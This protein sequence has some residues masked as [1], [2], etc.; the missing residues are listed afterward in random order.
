ME[1]P[2]LRR[3][4]AV[5]LLAGACFFVS[6]TTGRA[7]DRAWHPAA[8]AARLFDPFV[9]VWDFDCDFYPAGG[10]VT[11]FAG[12][13]SFRWILDGRAMQDIWVGYLRGT[14][15]GERGMGMSVRF[16]DARAAQWKVVFIAPEGGKIL[17]LKGGR[18]GDR[19]VLEGLD[20]DG[21]KLRW[22]F[23]D[24]HEDDFLWRGE[25]SSDEG[26]TWRTEQVM[27]LRRRAQAP[28]R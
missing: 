8:D 17:T 22:S 15:P 25:T 21:A 10:A 7:A 19:I 11:R 3:P 26:R 13:W 2:R 20:V 9:G 18:V 12:E 28:E 16:F 23:N 4:L 1:T 24:V 14:K 6:A 27:R 5:L